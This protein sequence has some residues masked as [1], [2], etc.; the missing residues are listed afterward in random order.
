MKIPKL[1]LLLLFFA[2][3]LSL[4]YLS[5]SREKFNV[6]HIEL[7]DGILSKTGPSQRYYKNNYSW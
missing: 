3:C 1:Y 7:V 4:S 2:I 6:E 5:K